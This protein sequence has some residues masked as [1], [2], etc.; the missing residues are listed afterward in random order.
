VLVLRLQE[1]RVRYWLLWSQEF[2]VVPRVMRVVSGGGALSRATHR[3]ARL[4]LSLCFQSEESNA[5]M[6][7]GPVGGRQSLWGEARLGTIEPGKELSG[8][9]WNRAPFFQVLEIRP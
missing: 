5:G 3:H 2:H 7:V 9:E 8:S 1:P 4:G 6:S